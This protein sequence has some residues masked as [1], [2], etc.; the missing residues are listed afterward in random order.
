MR[1]TRVPT[2]QEGSI[3]SLQNPLIMRGKLKTVELLF[4]AIIFAGKDSTMRTGGIVERVS[5]PA[6]GCMATVITSSSFK[7][8]FL[9]LIVPILALD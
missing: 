2:G 4:R 6:F 9:R 8:T 5:T 7:N 3:V 1:T